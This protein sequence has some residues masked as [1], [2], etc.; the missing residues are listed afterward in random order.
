MDTP[1]RVLLIEGSENDASPIMQGLRHSG[2]DPKFERVDTPEAFGAALAGQT[3]D[4]IIANYAMPQFSG[5]DALAMVKERDLDLPF[6]IVSDAIGE[7]VAVAA[8]RAG[9]YDYVMKD[10]LARLGPAVQRA[11]QEAGV[12]LAHRQAV[13]ALQ[14]SEERF[15]ALIENASDIIMILNRDATI[16]YGSPSMERVI[17]YEQEEF[18]GKRPRDFVHPDDL[19]VITNAFSHIIQ[20]PGVPL[21]VEFRIRH[22][23]GSWGV[24][25][26]IGSNLLDDP[27]VEG[28]IVNARHVTERRQT[29]ETLELRVEQLAALSQAS[30]AMTASLEL[31]EVLAEIIS[32]ANE[33][34]ESD[35]TSVVLVDETGNIGR[36]AE[37]L[38]GVPALEYRIRDDGLTSWIVRSHQPVI[39]DE[40]AEDGTI[41]LD[42]GEGAPRTANPPIVKAG[43]K[44]VAGLPLMVKER[45]LGVLYLHGLRV[46]A[47]RGQL[48]LLT[49]FANQ[50][51]IAIENARLFQGE[52]RQAKRLALLADVARIAATTLDADALLQAVSESIHRHFEY[53]LVQLF[54]LDDEQKTLILR[55]YSGVPLDSPELT[56]PGVYRLPIER[57]VTGYVART[58]RSHIAPDVRTDPYFHSP[59]G[60]PIRSSLCVPILSE[61]RVVGTVGVASDRLADF[62]EGAQSLLEATADA[63]GIGLRNALLHRETQRRLQELTLV[64]RIS[65]GFGAALDLDALING[66]LEGLHELANADHTY[67]ITA[68]PYARTWG[69]THER[70]APGIE[71]IIGQGGAFDDRP[72]ELGT[73]EAGQPFAVSD[74]ATDPRVEASRETYR[75]IGVQSMLLAPVQIGER[76]YGALGFNCRRERHAWQPDEIRL[77]EAVAHQLGLAL[78]NVRLFEEVRLRA[79]ELASALARLEEMD[80]LKDQF[81]Q[82]VSHELRSPL[83]LIRGYAEMLDTGELGGLQP[84]Q[85]QPVAIITRRARMLSDLVQD[86]TLILEAGVSSPE[87]EPVPLDELARAAAEDFQ[88]ACA[89]AE[90]TL[91]TEIAP[92]LPPVSGSP[93]YMR[94]VLDN[95]LN[96]AVKFTPAGGRITI[97]L[98]DEGKQIALEVSDT[99]IGIPADKL[100][101]IFERFYQVDG[102]ARRRYGGVG[103]GLALVKEIAEAYSGRVTVESKPDKGSIFT[104]Y[105]PV[106]VGTGMVDE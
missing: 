69:V 51:A 13:E 9:A 33:V 52:Q 17:G 63:V 10:D 57:G 72:V 80:R 36:S 94:R 40:I 66:A 67:F 61:G 37:N 59:G 41:S 5:L 106:A 34:V 83:S 92:Q 98:R 44:S 14:R 20:N 49:A 48:S 46:G 53:P 85:Q 97:R 103:L 88:I 15:R 82:N 7:D 43:V 76:L 39:I 23:G 71:S 64:N 58:G 96:N 47:F 21:Q 89:Q 105:L 55:G 75:S 24:Y 90:L 16:H 68:D 26:A 60:V 70:V 28:I 73:I 95:L 18:I 104:V 38:P 27:A 35:Y 86:I 1:L 32:L 102:S 56:A 11:L 77:L 74:I 29:Q 45:L 87:P 100:K 78:E 99:G 22:K 81:I 42:L 2:Y 3:W 93:A 91:C 54:T 12:R 4:I 101:R 30:Q 31:D 25:E 62:D 8:M 19:P 65:V 6:I 79:D 84:K 50:V